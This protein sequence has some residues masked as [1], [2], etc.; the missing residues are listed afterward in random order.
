ML[1]QVNSQTLALICHKVCPWH[2]MYLVQLNGCR[3][4]QGEILV[5]HTLVYILCNQN[6][7]EVSV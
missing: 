3:N 5:L 2:L 7:V 1:E 6:Q 4:D